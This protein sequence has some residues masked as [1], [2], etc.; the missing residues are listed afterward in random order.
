MALRIPPSIQA[1]I[2]GLSKK[3]AED[4]FKHIKQAIDDIYESRAS[5]MNYRAL[6]E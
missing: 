5:N 2:K 6:Y 1:K 4:K 3:E